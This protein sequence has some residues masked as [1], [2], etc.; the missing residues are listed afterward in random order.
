MTDAAAYARTAGSSPN[1][2]SIAN[3]NAVEIATRSAPVAARDVDRHQLA[4]QDERR[5][6]PEAPVA[7]RERLARDD[8]RADERRAERGDRG[9]VGAEPPAA[10]RRGRIG[11]FARHGRRGC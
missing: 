1:S 8:E 7:E 10:E 6:Q 5:H 2:S 11:G 3:A 9:A 4:D